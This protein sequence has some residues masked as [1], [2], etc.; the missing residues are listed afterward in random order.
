MVDKN[1]NKTDRSLILEKGFLRLLWIVKGSWISSGIVHGTFSDREPPPVVG[2]ICN[3]VS[4]ST[5]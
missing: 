4:L 1:K 2:S 5:G 3:Y